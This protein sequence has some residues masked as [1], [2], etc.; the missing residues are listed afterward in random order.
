M[1]MKNAIFDS[2]ILFLLTLGV[3]LCF[4]SFALAISGD[5]DGDG[6]VNVIDLSLFAEQWLANGCI[7]PDW[8][9]GADIDHSSSVDFGDFVSLAQN[10]STVMPV[11]S[12]E[13]EGTSVDT[14]KW[15]IYN[16]ADADDP[17]GWFRPENIAVSDGMLII[18]SAEELY[19]GRHWTGGYIDTAPVSSV[20]PQ[21]KYLV[22]RVRQSAPDTYI[23]PTWWTVGWVNNTLV[24]PPE[25]DICETQ[26]GPGK[27]PGQTYH[28]NS[29]GDVY[30]GC[31]T[32]IDESQWHTY[33][34]YWTAA[35]A[36]V[37][38]VD[39]VVSCTP[40]GPV[41]G[42]LVPMKLKLTSSPNHQNRY[43]GCPLGDF[44]VDYV[45]VY[46]NPP[47]PPPGVISQDKPTLASSAET[48]NPA[49][50]ANDGNTT[51]T[52]WAA[53]SATYPQWWA[54]YL[55][56]ISY[57][58]TRVDINWY[59]TSSRAY[60]YKIEVSDD[61]VSFTT[62]VDKTGNTTYGD[63]SDS[64]TATGKYVKVTVT[65]CTNGSAFASMY[66]V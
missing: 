66:E 24:W 14:S 64:F 45:R 40:A 15:N 38:Y 44:E 6:Y 7:P 50:N 33:G 52:R 8:C 49:A 43:S 19:N 31:S 20:H 42:A 48:A 23:W 25:L 59:S 61:W 36:P 11:W 13:F 34:T 57:N 9:G 56:A 10:W 2:K 47:Q 12:D 35:R 27:S 17:D 21:Y 28:W 16:Q 63:T 39:G 58:M 41:N 46:D 1:M 18:H 54:V 22:A 51:T 37:F 4:S 32:G 53:S 29:G 60:K 3:M 26:G 55:G 62:V 5:V 65:G 30:A